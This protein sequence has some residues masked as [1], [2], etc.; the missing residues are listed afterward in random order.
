MDVLERDFYEERRRKWR[1]N[2]FWRGFAVAFGVLF[3][4]GLIVGSTAGMRPASPHIAVFEIN[5]I[6]FDDPQ[7]DALLAEIRDAEAAKAVM[8]RINSPGGTTVG[9]EALHEAI[10]DIAETKPVVAVIGEVAASGGYI[11]A[12]AADHVIARGNSI[13]GSIGVIM[14]YPDVT[15]LMETLGVEMET[16]RSSDLKAEPSPFRPANPRATIL[17]QAM[18]DDSYQWFRSLVGERRNLSGN[19]LDEV[20]NGT[21]FTGR[22]ALENQLIDAIG[23]ADEARDYLESVDASL[24]D[25]SYELWEMP[26][27]E[28]GLGWLL[29]KFGMTDRFF[30]R[31]SPGQGPLLYSIFK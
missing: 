12:I 7:R 9:S 16:I 18:I 8:L 11:A 19:A 29:G 30:G 17:Q 6:I 21:V 26:R 23:G 3:L 13:T 25:L 10:R 27:E 5:D 28:D 24:S 15:G 14:E 20:A 4:I 31:F 22:M 2:A 1:R